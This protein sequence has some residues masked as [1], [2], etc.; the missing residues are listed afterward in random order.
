VRVKR[1]LNDS[2]VLPLPQMFKEAKP[3][4]QA[5]R[6]A[7]VLF[8]LRRSI[9]PRAHQAQAFHH[10]HQHFALLA[11]KV[12]HWFGALATEHC[13]IEFLLKTRRVCPLPGC[14]YLLCVLRYV[15]PLK[16]PCRLYRRDV[17]LFET[18]LEII[19]STRFF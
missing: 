16:S 5:L 15:H 8:R 12:V 17:L 9:S 7:V 18:I 4:V 13:V 1:V 19:P 6:A 10:T 2:I 3:G 11:L 14:Q